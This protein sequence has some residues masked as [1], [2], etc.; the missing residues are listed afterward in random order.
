MSDPITDSTQA[1]SKGS[2]PAAAPTALWTIW[3]I[4]DLAAILIGFAGPRLSASSLDLYSFQTL[5][6]AGTAALSPSGSSD[7]LAL[8]LALVSEISILAYCTVS[9]FRVCTR[10]TNPIWAELSFGLLVASLAGMSV[11]F[12]Y[13][14]FTGWGYWLAWAGLISSVFC[15]LRT[16]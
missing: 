9:I 15:E 12:Q 4:A 7:A 6:L 14:V 11:G 3:C 13:V 10:A 2:R 1:S 16:C 5:R 8:C